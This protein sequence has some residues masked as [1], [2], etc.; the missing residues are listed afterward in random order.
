MEELDV[1]SEFDSGFNKGFEEGWEAGEKAGKD[2]N[3]EKWVEWVEYIP[4]DYDF[5]NYDSYVEAIN[6]WYD[7][8]PRND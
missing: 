4:N 6:E 8:R 7:E 3:N 5:P 1:V 2:E